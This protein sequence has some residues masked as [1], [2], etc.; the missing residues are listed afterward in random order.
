MKTTLL[1]ITT[2]CLFAQYP[3]YA[4]T[5]NVNSFNDT[6]DVN[7]G[8]GICQDATGNCSLRAAVQEANASM[9]P[10]QIIL[11]AGN[12]LLTI[13]GSN[14]D[15]CL[16]GD[17]DI[18][19]DISIIGA[20]AWT[21]L[22][23]GNQL[24]RVFHVGIL[25]RL[26]IRQVTVTNGFLNQGAGA[27]FLNQ[28]FLDIYY[29]CIDSN[30][31]QMNQGLNQTGGLGGGIANY[32]TLNLHNSTLQ[33][34]I[35]RGAAGNNAK[36]GGG[37]G[38]GSPGLG[39]GLY[40][41]NLAIAT[42][43]NSTFSTN[44]ALGAWSSGGA[45]NGGNF[46][47][48]G[49]GGAGPTAGGGGAAGGGTGG[50]G[51]DFSGGGGGGSSC[52]TGGNGGSGGF[53]AGGGGRGARS[54]GGGNGLVGIAGFGGGNG[55]AS[56]CSSCGGGGAGSGMGGG[57]FNNG[58]TVNLVSCTVAFNEALGGFGRTGQ[59]GYAAR[60]LSAS[61][62][63]GGIFNRVG[64]F[65]FNNSIISNNIA[66]VQNNLSQAIANTADD[67][68]GTYTST[69]GHN[70]IMTPGLAVLVGNLIN[71]ILNV[72]PLLMPLANNGGANNTHETDPCT[73]SVVINAG[74]ASVPLD[75]RDIAQVL[76]ADI[77]AFEQED[78]CI[79][80]SRQNILLEGTKKKAGNLIEWED[81]SLG[82][83]DKF[84]LF[85]SSN[86]VDFKSIEVQNAFIN[87]EVYYQFLD[88]KL[89]SPTNY[90]RLKCFYKDASFAYSQTIA[91]ERKLNT[92][93]FIIAPNPFEDV[94]NI[95]WPS[96]WSG[97]ARIQMTDSKGSLV[98][99]KTHEVVG[100][101]TKIAP[102]NDISKG[103]YMLR[104]RFDEQVIVRKLIKQ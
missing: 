27:G 51:G 55:N 67:L 92:L 100:G 4:I 6:H 88:T 7:P 81:Q 28:G 64:N 22:I 77:G 44:R 39:G 3:T 47:F 5:F 38:G 69:D 87:N 89:L 46:S 85:S 102:G 52:A 14:E 29:C 32:Q 61:G 66:D 96:I 71:N 65:V 33:Y 37:G 95:E 10:D 17:L 60:G 70:L 101:N 84:E 21:T 11:G 48:A 78:P 97:K 62:F 40:N 76:Q 23:D 12:Y 19:S 1:A 15:A 56:C 99:D 9:G 42:L 20:N 54:C 45:T 86:G 53:G 8:D 72:D 59:G 35:A 31:C 73:P 94:L 57:I 58:G 50:N 104:V 68:F 63:G 83:F 82:L 25:G 49:A 43:T 91:L 16:S 24:D 26:L 41:E 2:L 98:Y 36:N 34:N 75:Q 93:P 13:A 90:Y 80:L 103:V 18:N 74:F 30:L 79:L